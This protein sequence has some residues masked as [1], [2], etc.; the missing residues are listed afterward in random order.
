[1]IYLNNG[2]VSPAEGF[3]ISEQDMKLFKLLL[4]NARANLD[5]HSLTKKESVSNEL[6]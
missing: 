4:V 1:M 2:S 5:V 3:L 6:I